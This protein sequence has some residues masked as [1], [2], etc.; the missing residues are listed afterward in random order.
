MKEENLIPPKL[1]DRILSWFVKGDLLEEISGDLYEYYMELGSIPSWKRAL[2]YWF[3]M[4]NFLRP[5]AIKKLEGSYQLNNYGMFK[6]YFKVGIRN[7]LKYKMFSFI[8]VFGLAV[9]MSVCMLIIL[10]LADQK[11]YDQ[12]HEKKDRV[13]RVLGTPEKGSVPYATT[14]LPTSKTIK[15]DYPI[16]EESIFLRQGV[17]GDATFEN[18]MTSLRGFFVSESFFDVLD[19]PMS[20]GDKRSALSEPNTMIITASKAYQLFNSENPIGKHVQ[21]SDRGLGIMDMDGD[22]PPVDWGTFKVTGVIDDSDFKSHLKFDVLASESTLPIL[23]KDGLIP[24]LSLEWDVYFTSYSYVLL[25]EGVSQSELDEAL[26]ELSDRKFAEL[27]GLEDYIFESQSLMKITPGM[28]INNEASFRLPII[29]YYILSVLALVIMIM[30]CLNYT[31]LSIARSL[32]RMKE[33]GIRKVNGA[34]RQSLISQFLTESIITVMFSLVLAFG[35]LYLV[36]EAFMNLW[37][38]EYLNFELQ[39]TPGVIFICIAFALLIGLIAGIYPALF[40]SRKPP[41]SA[42]KNS[43]QAAGKWGLHKFLNVSQFVVSLLFI[44]TS[45]VIFNQFKHYTTFEYGFDADNIV[46]IPL[47]SNDYEVMRA[48]LETVPGVVAISACEY[49]PATGTTDMTRFDNPNNENEPITLLQMK[50]NETFLSNIDVKI[51]AGQGL[52]SSGESKRFIV[53]N[54]SALP[55]LGYKNPQEAIGKIWSSSTGEKQIRG[56]I[57]DFRNTMLINGD[58]IRPTVLANDPNDFNFLNVRITEGNPTNILIELEDRWKRIDS[59]H[60][61]E[62]EF[63]AN[64]LANT[65]LFIFDIVSIIG[66]LSFLAILIACLGML[67]MATYTTERRTKEVGIRKVLGAAEMKIVIILSKNFL[68]LL[69]ISILIAAPLSYFANSFWL[70]NLPNRVDFGFGTVVIGSLL[71]LGLGLLTIGS[72]T[73]RAARQNPV[74]SLKDE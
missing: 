1:P 70:D 52:P 39:L 31:N 10:M 2:F 69:G 20:Q 71:M 60:E 46:N 5:F 41:I 11:S 25:K 42:L 14:P 24:D 40:L 64:D 48:E 29:A 43:D 56:V 65:N 19:Y 16:V 21:F 15:D 18:K 66:Y 54:E 47:Q 74:E 44:V 59:K 4:V 27:E 32:S 33:I 9:A 6:N 35:I 7:I 57:E 37:A 8:N 61:F 28:L 17:G 72:Q 34:R 30:A 62:Y 68:K 3:H 12:F 50:V 45:I 55:K 63:F 49:I 67:G 13:Y 53:I 51:I 58:E 38:N 22:R 26:T 23:Y 36:K 73:I